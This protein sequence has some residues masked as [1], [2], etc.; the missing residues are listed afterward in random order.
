MQEGSFQ[1]NLCALHNTHYCQVKCKVSKDISDRE[2]AKL[3][4]A[5]T[6]LHQVQQAATGRLGLTSVTH[7]N[8]T[9]DL[10]LSPFA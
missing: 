9:L 3:P 6:Q 5:Q 7:A 2:I 4:N 10:A 1:R 8:M